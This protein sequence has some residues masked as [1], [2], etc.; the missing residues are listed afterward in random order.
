MKYKCIDIDTKIFHNTYGDYPVIPSIKKNRNIRDRF[1]YASMG[2]IGRNPFLNWIQGFNVA[3]IY[4]EQRAAIEIGSKAIAKH[5][6]DDRFLILPT[7]LD[8]SYS[9]LNNTIFEYNKLLNAWNEISK[10]ISSRGELIE[11]IVS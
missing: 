6:R 1:F 7:A 9:K 11:D 8:L 2:W 5:L 10:K 3:E 4:E